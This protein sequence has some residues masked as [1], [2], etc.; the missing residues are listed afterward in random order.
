MNL[1]DY[2]AIGRGRATELVAAINDLLS[3]A[4]AEGNISVSYL[5]QMA[6]RRRPVPA[7]L[8]PFIAEWTGVMR[9]H[10]RPNDWWLIWPDL[11]DHP[12]APP[13]P[14]PAARPESIGA[15]LS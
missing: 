4:G 15:P 13:L 12:D 8:A 14:A 5:G 9:W 7:H 10:L 1:H 2:L 6:T 11:R 3:Q